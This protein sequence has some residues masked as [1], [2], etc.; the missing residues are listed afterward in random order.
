MVDSS[1]LHGHVQKGLTLLAV[2]LRSGV[3]RALGAIAPGA[4]G[5]A[6]AGARVAVTYAAPSQSSPIAGTITP[7]T[8]AVLD[9]RTGRRLYR[10]SAPVPFNQLALTTEVDARGDVLV[11]ST[12]FH[13]PAPQSSGWWAT[14]AAP[15]PHELRSLVTAGQVVFNTPP[16]GYTVI[17]GAA[18]LAQGRIAYVTDTPKG[19]QID[20]L[21][22]R[23]GALRPVVGFTGVARVVGLDLSA[24][25]L[26]WAQ[27][28]TVTEVSSGP[29]PGGG[30]FERCSTVAVGPVQLNRVDL[31]HLPATPPEIGAPVPKAD[32]RLCIK[33]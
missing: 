24:E 15:T 31:G 18:A 33:S 1:C 21:D 19:E 10:V 25:E 29:V 26:A 22:L 2:N 6:S 17:T 11:T 5:L 9:A 23:S 28:S 27:Q 13:P 7:V 32:E 12:I 4:V 8:T 20:L 3:R 16:Y 30:Y 14:P